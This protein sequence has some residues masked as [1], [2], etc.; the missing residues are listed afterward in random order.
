[1]K[2][3]GLSFFVGLTFFV[4]H[5]ISALS[6]SGIIIENNTGYNF[7]VES[8]TTVK[9]KKVV[10]TYKTKIFRG[11]LGD[12]KKKGMHCYIDVALPH[13]K[14]IREGRRQVLSDNSRTKYPKKLVVGT[15][16]SK[17]IF[18]I[19]RDQASIKYKKWWPEI[20]D[21]EEVPSGLRKAFS[22]EYPF[23]KKIVRLVGGGGHIDL[24][25]ISERIGSLNASPIGAL[26]GAGVL[27]IPGI[28]LVAS[29]LAGLIVGMVLDQK[30]FLFMKKP[31]I[32]NLNVKIRYASI[33]SAAPYHS[34]KISIDPS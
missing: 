9:G 26:V 4:F 15:E 11:S 3:K 28:G 18:K 34:L 10:P 24:E 5:G 20:E 2:Q 32:E 19:D 25:F 21:P 29:G 22:R 16:K 12:L 6:K 8:I 31:K 13:W 33:G 27:L 17:K 30:S 1:M 14:C 23:E 7:K